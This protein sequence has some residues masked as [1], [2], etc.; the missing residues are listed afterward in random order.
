VSRRKHS[1]PYRRLRF[2]YRHL[3]RRLCSV[4]LDIYFLYQPRRT[5]VRA[6]FGFG[7]AAIAVMVLMG[8]SA[9]PLLRG[10][11]ILSW[12][13][14]PVFMLVIYL[15]LGTAVGQLLHK[16]LGPMSQSLKDHKG[17][18]ERDELAGHFMGVVAVIYA[19][20]VAF[21]VVNAWQGRSDA[22]SIATQE[23][24]D[25]DDL[26]H[27]ILPH[28]KPESNR[29]LVMLR[30]YAM[31]TQGEWYQM[32]DA[33]T[34][35][36]DTSESSPECLGPAGAISSRANELAHCIRDYAFGL[37][38]VSE[39]GASYEEAIRMTAA[40]SE[41]RAERRLR[42]KYR[43]LQP[44]LLLSF[45]LGAFI[46]IGMTYFVRGQ[47]HRGQLVRTTALFAM[48]GMMIAL[49]LIFD[50]PFV[51]SMQVTP[52]DWK[53][54]VDHFDRDLSEHKIPGADLHKACPPLADQTSPPT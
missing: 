34:L 6:L 39:E 5:A 46:L 18:G 41:D 33:A 17:E 36:T 48:M 8:L 25:V 47:G 40:F 24:H 51:G 28:N 29:V 49:A 22:T 52:D 3:H 20:L 1:R 14:G 32:R 15:L 45:I 30:Y 26:F 43:T 50:R 53:A 37:R 13:T 4:Y 16:A 19:V 7:A 21:V 44:V 10:V 42:Y 54:L 12:H 31:Y 27:L 38:A 9:L 23:Q 2:A 35:C 11:S